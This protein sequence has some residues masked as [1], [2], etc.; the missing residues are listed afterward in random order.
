MAASNAENRNE[1]LG[2]WL[3]R[4]GA[5]KLWV[6]PVPGAA[7]QAYLVNGRV[8]LVLRHV[9]GQDWELFVPASTSNQTDRI[10]ADAALALGLE[11]C[12][13]LDAEEAGT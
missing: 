13:G 8:A 12:S 11:D 10:L 5:S 2:K 9:V 1:Q 4:M 7:I 3:G 6:V